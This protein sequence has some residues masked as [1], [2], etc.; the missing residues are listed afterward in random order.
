MSD[1]RIRRRYGFGAGQVRLSP[2]SLGMT[3]RPASP[4]AGLCQ[5]GAE[6]RAGGPTQSLRRAGMLTGSLGIGAML[7][8]ALLAGF[9]ADQQDLTDLQ[10]V[11]LVL[12]EPS[13]T[14]PVAAVAAETAPAMLAPR[15]AESVPESRSSVVVPRPELPQLI[16]LEVFE[17]PA[18]VIPEASMPRPEP[19]REAP[20]PVIQIAAVARPLEENSQNTARASRIVS[21]LPR[22]DSRVPVDV[23]PVARNTEPRPPRTV[24]TRI[25]RAAR[26]SL[27]AAPG[28]APARVAPVSLA[29]STGSDDEAGRSGA[30]PRVVRRGVLRDRS[31]A[32]STQPAALTA[33]AFS[34]RHKSAAAFDVVRVSSRS[35]SR[36]SDPAVRSTAHSQID[37]SLEGVPLS[38]L[39][40]CMS[41]R[42][43]DALKLDVLEAISRPAEC[44]SPA[45]R[46]R[47]VETK[48]LN[49]FL[50]WIERSPQRE[51]V[52]RCAELRHALDCL[53]NVGRHGGST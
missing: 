41:D 16:A 24:P 43:E 31:A 47:F 7:L 4:L 18:S 33:A 23:D 36:P 34:A 40:A 8:V 15:L 2:A 46:Y 25:S 6:L 21:E 45:G 3:G 39:A 1:W 27:A 13:A 35:G 26:P 12:P 48:N 53:H 37:D 10:I 20:R 28:R 11:E 22:P 52:D 32:R 5:L 50:M 14:E 17:P 49:A 38:S 9:Q 42:E 44:V 51:K 29:V 19:V 30:L